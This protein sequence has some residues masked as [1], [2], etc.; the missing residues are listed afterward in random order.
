MKARERAETVKAMLVRTGILDQRNPMNE[1]AA[2]GIL[3]AALNAAEAD[4]REACAR[5]VDGWRAFKASS[6]MADSIRAR[7]K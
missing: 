2:L 5:V 6:D 4:E 3:E 1:V 7:G